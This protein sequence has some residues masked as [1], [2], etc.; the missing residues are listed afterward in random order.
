MTDHR[1]AGML[2]LVARIG[3]ARAA[4]LDVERLADELDDDKLA[5]EVYIA[6]AGILGTAD[7]LEQLIAPLPEMEAA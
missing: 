5:A 2:E 3:I 6:R 4:W 1:L 7:R